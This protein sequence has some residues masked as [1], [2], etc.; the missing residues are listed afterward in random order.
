MSNPKVTVTFPAP[1]SSD[2]NARIA[3]I[4]DALET[5]GANRV[6]LELEATQLG[7]E[8]FAAAVAEGALS[9]SMAYDLAIMV[10]STLRMCGFA[11]TR[12]SK[13]K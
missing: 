5:G 3:A 1:L 12:A 10:V 7:I 6:R 8:R 11:I 2:F 13:R 9:R 4:R